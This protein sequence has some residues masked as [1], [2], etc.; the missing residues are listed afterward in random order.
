MVLSC[1]PVILYDKGMSFFLAVVLILVALVF[2]AKSADLIVETAIYVSRRFGINEFNLGFFVLGLATTTPEL[3]I[4]INAAIDDKSYLSLGNLI[5]ASIVLLT[6]IIGLSAIITNEVHFIKNFSR[7]DML[8]TSFIII[9]PVLFSLDGNLS[10]LDGM[11][12]LCFYLI[13]VFVLNREQKF[14]DRLEQSFTHNHNHLTG[15]IFKTIIGI[16]GLFLSSKIILETTK[17]LAIQLNIPLVLLGLLLIALG[18]NLPEII[19]MIKTLTLRHKQ[20]GTGDFLGSAVANTPVLALVALIRPI[21]LESPQKMYFS[22]GILIVALITFNAFFS[23]H[24]KITRIEGAALIA[25]YTFFVFSE[26]FMK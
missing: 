10:R 5:G 11:I 23:S 4:G 15:I 25:I 17:F 26:I 16:V 9:S 24:K 7:K 1:F 14:T 13:F 18:T 8:F 2:L 3:F 22:F 12:M 21:Y 19:L 6:L 20:L